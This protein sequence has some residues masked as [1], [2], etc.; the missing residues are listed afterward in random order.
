MKRISPSDIYDWGP[1]VITE[2]VGKN[3]YFYVLDTNSGQM[4]QVDQM[5]ADLCGRIDGK[6]KFSQILQAIARRQKLKVKDVLPLAET[7]LAQLLKK[8]LLVKI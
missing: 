8:K 5:A 6:K 4:F 2:S 3:S 7:F 1:G